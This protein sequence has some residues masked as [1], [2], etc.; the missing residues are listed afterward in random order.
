[1]EGRTKQNT[2]AGLVPAGRKGE[3]KMR[4]T[5]ARKGYYKRLAQ[6]GLRT[7]GWFVA[8]GFCF[9]AGVALGSLLQGRLPAQRLELLSGL[10]PAGE[11]QGGFLAAAAACAVSMAGVLALFLFLGFCAI[12]QPAV[13]LTLFLQGVGF[14]L[15]GAML[16]AQGGQ[17]W[18]YML[19]LTPR[20]V[21]W[22][23][24]AAL[25]ARESLRM[26][27]SFLAAAFPEGERKPFPIRFYLG[28]YCLL[29]VGAILYGL[30]N[31][32]LQALYQRLF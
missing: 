27:S 24:L 21:L 30:A 7:R 26:S 6:Y 31:G 1:M 11:I 10:L 17:R 8:M 28:R 13:I 12:A 22:L 25:A 16:L 19:V 5:G 23:S 14:G 2:A 4:R 18:Y 15:A 29:G 20:M 9:L 32:L 3:G